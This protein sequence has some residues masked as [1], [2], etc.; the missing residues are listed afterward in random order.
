MD[1]RDGRDRRDRQRERQR[2][3]E[4]DRQTDRERQACNI[5]KWDTPRR[6]GYL[7]EHS[8]LLDDSI[9]F[10][11]RLHGD[12]HGFRGCY[13]ATIIVITHPSMDPL[14]DELTCKQDSH[15]S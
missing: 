3:T 11:L 6:D 7:K 4:R 13:A 8:V 10:F 9:E 5:D 12:E 2:E 14:F 1:T 15:S